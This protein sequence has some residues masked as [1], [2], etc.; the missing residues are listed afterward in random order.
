M[1]IRISALI[2][3]SALCLI[4]ERESYLANKVELF[5]ENPEG[6]STIIQMTRRDAK[7]LDYFFQKLIIGNPFA[8]TLAGSKPVSMTSFRNRFTIFSPSNLRFVL[9][10]KTWEKYKYFCDNSEILYWTEKNSWV[11]D[12]TLIVLANK[13][14]CIEL[15]EQNKQDF[16]KITDEKNPIKIIKKRPFFKNSLKN[17]EALIGMILGFGKENSWLY[18][19]RFKDYFKFSTQKKLNQKNLPSIWGKIIE[20]Q[21]RNLYFKSLIFK[22]WKIEDMV[23][24]N[25]VGDPESTESKALKQEYLKTKEKLICYY[26]NRNFL[27]ATLSLYKHGP[28]ILDSGTYR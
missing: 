22:S 2:I 28:S 10:W 5:I 25:F 24:P 6:N 20:R 21:S 17:H 13:N 14:L 16:Q 4:L 26:K 23:L 1:K 15:I 19:Y 3:I 11:K 27:E 9:G 12:S 8:F 18:Y 7:R